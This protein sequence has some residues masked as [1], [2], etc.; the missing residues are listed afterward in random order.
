MT[1]DDNDDDKLTVCLLQPRLRNDDESP[2]QATDQVIQMMMMQQ[3]QQQQEAS[4][5]ASVTAS[6]GTERHAVDLYVLPELCP[7]GYS[8]DTFANYLPA[9]ETLQAMY[10][11]IDEKLQQAAL[12]LKSYICY[13]TIGWKRQDQHQGQDQDHHEGQLHEGQSK[14]QY[15]IRQVVVD[16][17]GH[18]IASYDK[19]H[20]CNY[21][22]CA[23]TRFF[24]PGETLV[25]FQIGPFWKLGIIICA[26]MRYPNLCRKLTSTSATSASASANSTSGDDHGHGVDVI[27]QPA[28]FA[29]DIAF[30]TWR[31]F[32]T[33]RAVE[34][35][36]YFVAGNYAGDNFGASSITPPW[37][38]DEDDNHVPKV[39]DNKVGYMLQTLHR[40]VLQHARTTLPFHKHVTQS[41]CRGCGGSSCC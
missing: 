41:S 35:G 32:C 9:N 15:F 26:D 14:F 8:E 39:M 1:P 29:R 5:S 24:T 3:Q 7:V 16:P 33:T 23:E 38:D 22:V 40:S 13:G 37:V 20:P 28:C 34:N 6:T 4:A 36:V 27:L 19:I 30:P 11:Q 18:Q 12:S 10:R 31:A 2:L 21:G 25:S 17:T